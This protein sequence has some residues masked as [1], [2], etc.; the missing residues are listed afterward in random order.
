MGRL[1]EK[2]IIIT[3]AASGMG[4]AMAILFAKEGASVMATDIQTDKLK[5]WVDKIQADG[6]KIKYATHD[7]TNEEH[8]KEVVHQTLE[9]F[10]KID[11][12]VNNAGIYPGYIDIEN[13]TNDLW[14]KI[15]NINLTGPFLGCRTV[16]PLLRKNN[17]GVILNIA[18]IAG[19]VGGNGAAYSASKAGLLLLTKDMAVTLA[20]DNIRVN[21]IAP[22]GVLTPMTEQLISIPEMKDIIKT[23]SPQGRMATAEEI[24]TGALFLMSD[25]SSFVTGETLVMDGGAVSR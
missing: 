7:V 14:Q 1:K 3:G 24:A 10:S 2:V 21:A 11:G 6:L 15:L 12:L 16:I 25:E 23:M 18:S 22:G 19:L 20:K 4:K 8:W 17:N 13:T 5:E 9:S